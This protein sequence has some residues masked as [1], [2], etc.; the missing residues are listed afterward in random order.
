M[1]SWSACMPVQQGCKMDRVEAY[2]VI[3][4]GCLHGCLQQEIALIRP[5]VVLLALG[6]GLLCFLI[7]RRTPIFLAV[8]WRKMEALYACLSQ[9]QM[10]SPRALI[11]VAATYPVSFRQSERFLIY[12]VSIFCQC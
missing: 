9:Q 2:L 3:Q 11:Y 7:L 1:H 8:M 4:H 10:V 5:R 6:P 12:A